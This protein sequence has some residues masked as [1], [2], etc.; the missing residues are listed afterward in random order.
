MNGKEAKQRI[1]K[2][3]KEIWHHNY[4]YHAL[5]SPKISDATWDSLKAE[6]NI[7][8]QKYP[9]LITIDSPTQRVNGKPL[10]KFKK[11]K[12]KILMLSIEDIFSEEELYAWEKR[13]KKLIPEKKL[14]YFAEM[15]IDG[16]AVSLIYKNGIFIKGATRGDGKI[17]ED[18]TQNLRTISSIP[19]NLGNFNSEIRGEVYMD[20]KVFEKINKQ[21][22]KQGLSLYANPRNI[23]AG[24]IRQLD[25]KLAASRELK[26]M[27]YDISV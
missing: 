18:V 8:E 17:G 2:L 26:F 24:S 25:A 23:A 3:K 1:K 12:H 11:V 9:H 13:I 10:S 22:K 27:A 6:L 19:L 4:L 7:L 5:D 15:K 21:R 16:F 20:K 14:S